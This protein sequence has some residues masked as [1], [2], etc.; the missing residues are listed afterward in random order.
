ME[1]TKLRRWEPENFMRKPV[2]L[3]SQEKKKKTV[4]TVQ[5]KQEGLDIKF[6][7][8]GL[9][10]VRKVKYNKKCYRAGLRYAEE[11]RNT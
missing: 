5:A 4:Q 2:R 10:G 3:E 8:V 9:G 6:D 1:A 7:S 11:G